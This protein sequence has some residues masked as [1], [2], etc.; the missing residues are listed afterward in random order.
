MMR[1]GAVKIMMK[2]IK[3]GIDQHLFRLANRL[4]MRYTEKGIKQWE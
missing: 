4:L 2:Y 1:N 3:G